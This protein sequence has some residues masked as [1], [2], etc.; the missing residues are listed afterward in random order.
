[1]SERRWRTRCWKCKTYG[2]L[3]DFLWIIDGKYWCRNC[4][5]RGD[6]T[7]AAGKWITPVTP[8]VSTETGEA[9]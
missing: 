6:S 5:P 7:V 8:P 2:P 4:A 1:M 9:L 3:F